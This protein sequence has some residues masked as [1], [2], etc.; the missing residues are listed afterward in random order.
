LCG[1]ISQRSETHTFGLQAEYEAPRQ[2]ANVAMMT[3][4]DGLKRI[5]EPQRGVLAGLRGAGLSIINSAPP[6]KEQILKYAMG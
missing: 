2:R 1:K 6:I 3:A 5:F 4:L